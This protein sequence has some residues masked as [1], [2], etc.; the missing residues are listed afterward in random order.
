MTRKPIVIAACAPASHSFVAP[1][2]NAAAERVIKGRERNPQ[3]IREHVARMLDHQ[4]RILER[5]GGAGAN[6]AVIPEDSLRL[7]GLVSRQGGKPFCATA[8]DEA[9]DQ[10]VQRIAAIC[11]RYR[12]HVAGG[13]VTRSRGRFHNTALLQDPA[14]RIIAAYHKTHL[15]KEEVKCIAPGN[16]LPVF[17]TLLGRIG[18]LICW[19]IVFPEPYA[20]LA[21]KGA[22][23]I[24]QPTFGHWD[25]SHDVTARSRAIDWCVPLVVSMWGGCACI[26]DR[27]GSFAARTGHAPDSIAVAKLDLA[28]R[29]KW[30]WLSDVRRQKPALRRSELYGMLSRK[31]RR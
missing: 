27:D 28:A 5:A 24:I 20:V 31:M 23:L 9:Y 17:D 14:G 8:I 10:Y 6:L 18:M 2:H 19:D 1:E 26:I 29:R 13:T 30:L 12:M 3:R 21:L 11:R 4:A 7:V 22:E 16:D 25:E 15:P